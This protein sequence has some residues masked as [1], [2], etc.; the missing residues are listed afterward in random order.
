MQERLGA[1]QAQ[2]AG[3]GPLMDAALRQ[4]AAAFRARSVEGVKAAGETFSSLARFDPRS[5]MRTSRS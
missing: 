3:I 2:R 5:W 4:W 1:L